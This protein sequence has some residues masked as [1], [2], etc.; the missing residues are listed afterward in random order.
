MNKIITIIMQP[1]KELVVL[2]DQKE[3]FRIPKD[4]RTIG[5]EELYKLFDYNLGDTFEIVKENPSNLDAPV[6]DFFYDLIK[7]IAEQIS[8]YTEAQDDLCSDVDKNE[9]EPSE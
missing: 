8:S 7:E 5:A 3:E 2:R 9:N 1:N 6:V 4:K